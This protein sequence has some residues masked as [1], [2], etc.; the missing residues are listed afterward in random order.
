MEPIRPPE[1]WSFG[2]KLREFRSA[3][4]PSQDELADR[5]GLRARGIS[6][7]ECGARGH[8]RFETVRLLADALDLEL[9]KRADLVAAARGTASITPSAVAPTI[10]VVRS[11]SHPAT[12]LIGAAEALRERHGLGEIPHEERLRR[13]R[14]F[15]LASA[16]LSTEK[17]ASALAAERELTRDQAIAEALEVARAVTTE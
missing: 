1:A 12:R 2:A 9:A 6:D 4:G 8:P 17:F 13:E 14:N 10:T 7:L 16:Q 15:A 3:A 5:T 11:L